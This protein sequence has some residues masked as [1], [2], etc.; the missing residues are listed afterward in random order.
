MLFLNNISAS[1]KVTLRNLLDS[2][3]AELMKHPLMQYTN[4]KVRFTIENE[5]LEDL[6]MERYFILSYQQYD[7]TTLALFNQWAPHHF[8]Q[9]YRKIQNTVNRFFQF[10]GLQNFRELLV[11][12]SLKSSPAI[13]E[14]L[15]RHSTKMWNIDR[16]CINNEFY[17]RAII[18]KNVALVKWMQSIVPMDAMSVE[19]FLFFSM[20]TEQISLYK[21]IMDIYPE[22]SVKHT[23]SH[24]F[25]ARNH[26]LSSFLELIIR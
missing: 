6:I 18:N 24:Q 20:T 22:E 10:N 12:P 9:I 16:F 21:W 17:A 11:N 7:E 8:L 2:K 4:A 1:Q 14:Y 23:T 5:K 15:S 13:I 26:N 25:Y 19:S 3:N